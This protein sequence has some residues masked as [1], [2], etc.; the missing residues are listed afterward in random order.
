[1]SV[2]CFKL[3]HLTYITFVCCYLK[4]KSNGKLIIF[5]YTY[6][7]KVKKKKCLNCIHDT[8][9][10][11]INLLHNFIGYQRQIKIYSVI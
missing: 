3:T 9:S 8:Q 10:S 2:P 1:M 7:P 6:Y 11:K 4:F 5:Y